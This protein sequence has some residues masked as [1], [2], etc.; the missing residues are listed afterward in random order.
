VKEKRY[1]FMLSFLFL[2]LAR[3]SKKSRRFHNW[4]ADARDWAISRNRY[5]GT[6]LPIWAS[7]D[8][9]E[10][11]VIGSVAELEK[12]S[13]RTGIQDIH[14]HLFVRCA[15]AFIRL[16]FTYLLVVQHRRHRD[17]V[18]EGQGCSSARARGV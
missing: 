13:G 7:E 5:W 1:G 17:S 11:V 18:P 4:L 10:V 12:L 3:L 9:E 6:P 15:T 16:V 8:F 2:R 14:R